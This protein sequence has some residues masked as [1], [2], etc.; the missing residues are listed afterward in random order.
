M[1]GHAP[2]SPVGR[3]II[4]GRRPR[5]AKNEPARSRSGFQT[6]VTA[7][8]LM[9]PVVNGGDPWREIKARERLVISCFIA[10]I[11]F[12]GGFAIRVSPFTIGSDKS[13]ADMAVHFCRIGSFL[14]LSKTNGNCRNPD[15]RCQVFPYMVLV[16]GYTPMAHR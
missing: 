8:A 13:P 1:I 11:P 14:K 15:R 2:N 4:R 16:N 3:R 10:Y 5:E 9:S 6:Q 12:S 7:L